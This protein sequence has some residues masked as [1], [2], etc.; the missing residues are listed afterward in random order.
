MMRVLPGKRVSGPFSLVSVQRLVGSGD[1]LVNGCGVT[2]V[3]MHDAHAERQPIRRSAARIVV[4]HALPQAGSDSPGT[5]AGF[6]HREH[7]K[8]IAAKAGDDVGMTKGL[9]QYTGC[10][11]QSF[12]AG[13]M[14]KAVIDLLEAV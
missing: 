3:K 7:Y 13:L 12:V 5:V 11:D 1:H 6:L 9:F 8:L 14:T 10:L 2:H 4:L